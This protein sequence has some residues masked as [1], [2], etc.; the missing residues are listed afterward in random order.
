[1]KD[2]VSKKQT[3]RQPIRVVVTLE[4]VGIVKDSSIRAEVP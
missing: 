2:M 3:E 4:S 1:M